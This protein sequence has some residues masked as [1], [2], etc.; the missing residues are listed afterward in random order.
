MKSLTIE[1]SKESETMIY[2]LATEP[3]AG[4]EHHEQKDEEMLYDT[5]QT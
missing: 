1:P 4:N 3:L 2:I 5:L